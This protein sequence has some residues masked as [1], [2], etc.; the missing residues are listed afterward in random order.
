M[1]DGIF[2]YAYSASPPIFTVKSRSS[3]DTKLIILRL[4]LEPPVMNSADI[5]TL[6]EKTTLMNLLPSTARLK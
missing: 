3:A 5:Y 1:Q 6:S 2:K 4:P